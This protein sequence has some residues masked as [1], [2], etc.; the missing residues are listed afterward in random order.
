LVH[1]LSGECFPMTSFSLLSAKVF[2]P[3]HKFGTNVRTQ[4]S[5][6]M[7]YS[8][9]CLCHFEPSRSPSKEH[10]CLSRKKNLCPRNNKF[11]GHLRDHWSHLP[12]TWQV[13]GI[14]WM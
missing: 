6:Q 1:H 10:Y 11:K 2:I 4:T 12:A 8:L 7:W 5:T 13:V 14:T 9:I 3:E